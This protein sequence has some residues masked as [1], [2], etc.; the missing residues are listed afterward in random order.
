MVVKNQLEETKMEKVISRATGMSPKDTELLIERNSFLGCPENLL[1]RNQKGSSPDPQFSLYKS[2][3]QILRSSRR[4]SDPV[5]EQCH[6][7]SLDP[8]F[9]AFMTSAE[10]PCKLPTRASTTKIAERSGLMTSW[11]YYLP[12]MLGKHKRTK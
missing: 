11:I 4:K 9:R 12:S 2:F 3:M 1:P 6:L 7:E 8:T 5:S 10:T